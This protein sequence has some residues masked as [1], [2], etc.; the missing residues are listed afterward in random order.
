MPLQS[1]TPYLQPTQPTQRYQ[2]PVEHVRPASDSDIDLAGRRL[3]GDYAD[4]IRSSNSDLDELDE[5]A[6]IDEQLDPM[7]IVLRGRSGD[8]V[9]IESVQTG[10]SEPKYR[11]LLER[12]N[13]SLGVF[14]DVTFDKVRPRIKQVI[15]QGFASKKSPEEIELA[16]DKIWEEYNKPMFKERSLNFEGARA[17]L[18]S[19]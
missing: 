19:S 14:D 12:V 7:D 9:N 1:Q 18:P 3:I 2:A 15:E 4:S 10:Y 11:D 5:I 16:L 6:G 8:P 17:E 13:L